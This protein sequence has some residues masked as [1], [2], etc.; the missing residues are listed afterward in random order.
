[1][2]KKTKI[3][4]KDIIFMIWGFVGSCV[5]GSL[6]ISNDLGYLTGNSVKVMN[7]IE[8]NVGLTIL[9]V[10]GFLCFLLLSFLISKLLKL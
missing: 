2:R 4:I 1:M 7:F 5:L 10:I 3:I 9:P 8:S 6:L